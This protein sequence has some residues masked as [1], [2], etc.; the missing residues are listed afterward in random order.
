MYVEL[1]AY[2][3][4]SVCFS[5]TYHLYIM[6][7]S[8]FISGFGAGNICLH[9]LIMPVNLILSIPHLHFQNIQCFILTMPLKIVAESVVLLIDP[10]YEMVSRIC[11]TSV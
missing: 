4:Q 1:V 8:Y 9:I 7:T 11:V 6:H 10:S 2:A 5:T 3:F